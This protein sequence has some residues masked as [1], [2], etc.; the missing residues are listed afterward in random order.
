MSYQ[1][2]VYK[3]SSDVSLTLPLSLRL[4]DYV[5]EKQHFESQGRMTDR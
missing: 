2:L 5:K 4:E 3:F 1:K